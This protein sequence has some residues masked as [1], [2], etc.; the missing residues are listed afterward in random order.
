MDIDPSQLEIRTVLVILSHLTQELR[1]AVPESERGAVQNEEEARKA[2]A[3][4]LQATETANV[5]PAE[6]ELSDAQA[7]RAARETLA[8]LLNDP[9]IAAKVL[10]LVENE[11]ADSQ[12]SVE[13]AASGAIVLGMLITWL[14]TKVD[15]KVRRKDGNVD[16]EFNLRKDAASSNLI[17]TVAGAVKKALFL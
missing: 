14:Q 2:L 3:T 16:F 6:V 17:T 1:Q 15:L 10:T 9:A 5:S 8:L 11:P 4:L 12:L 7:D 13:L